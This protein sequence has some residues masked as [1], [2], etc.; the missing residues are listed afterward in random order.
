MH[1]PYVDRPPSLFTRKSRCP[2]IKRDRIKNL[3][4]ATKSQSIQNNYL[5]S[6]QR[7][8]HYYPSYIWTEYHYT[9]IAFT[10][11]TSIKTPSTVVFYNVRQLA[12]T[13]KTKSEVIVSYNSAQPLGY[14]IQASRPK[15]IPNDNHRSHI[16]ISK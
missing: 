1:P 6:R 5:S 12:I 14:N 8:H 9:L 3:S 15:P 4:E 7:L 11:Y 16:A 13:Y 2:S 10:G